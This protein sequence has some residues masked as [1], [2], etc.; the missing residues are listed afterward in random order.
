[1]PLRPVRLP[2]RP[3]SPLGASPPLIEHHGIVSAG[4]LSFVRVATLPLQP[5]RSKCIICARDTGVGIFCWRVYR[6]FKHSTG[7]QGKRRSATRLFFRSLLACCILLFFVSTVRLCTASAFPYL[8]G[9]SH[10]G[11][12]SKVDRASETGVEGTGDIAVGSQ[13]LRLLEPPSAHAR[14]VAPAAALPGVFRY[15]RSSH[16]R[17]PPAY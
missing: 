6:M 1:M 4:P 11:H 2:I 12:S 5:L 17:S 10:S 8:R 7:A 3:R 13:A 9:S 15:L 16:F 14:F